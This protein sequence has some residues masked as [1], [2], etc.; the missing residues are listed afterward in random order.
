MTSNKPGKPMPVRVPSDDCVITRDGME[1]RLHEGEWIEVIRGQMVGQIQ[2]G[3]KLARAAPSIA[4]VQG[5]EDE[6]TQVLSIIGN[7]VDDAVAL[8]R[9]RIT[10]WNWTGMDGEPLP[11][12]G[13]EP[14]VFSRLEVEEL[15]Y[16]VGALNETTAERGNDLRPSVNTFSATARPRGRK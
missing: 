13:D 6:T 1:Y 15:W 10:G 7:A 9:S 8:L 3:H 11:Q 4:A 5:D 2:L 12:P 16:L 14:D